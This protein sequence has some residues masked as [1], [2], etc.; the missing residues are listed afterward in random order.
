MLIALILASDPL[1]SEKGKVKKLKENK[2]LLFLYDITIRSK[3]QW[4]EINQRVNKIKKK[5]KKKKQK[6]RLIQLFSSFF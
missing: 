2:E 1:M 6:R 4:F 5:K 3:C